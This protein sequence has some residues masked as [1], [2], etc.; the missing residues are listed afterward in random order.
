MFGK[1]K[2]EF[3]KEVQELIEM[4]EKRTAAISKEQAM[5]HLLDTEKS[6]DLVSLLKIAES[7]P[8]G[9]SKAILYAFR[10]GYLAGS[11]T[12]EPNATSDNR[13]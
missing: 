11:G 6:W 5:D 2:K 7:E 12:L 10:L 8:L 9:K 3:Q 13:N 1:K 4:Y